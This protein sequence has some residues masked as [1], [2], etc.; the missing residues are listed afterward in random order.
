[1]LHSNLGL[2]EQAEK[3]AAT[4]MTDSCQGRAKRLE[5]L[6]RIKCPACLGFHGS[7]NLL[8]NLLMNYDEYWDYY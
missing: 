1:M 2:D 8:E 5:S 6:K 4:R 7:G 3:Q